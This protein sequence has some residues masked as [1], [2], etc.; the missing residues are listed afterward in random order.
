MARFLFSLRI[1]VPPLCIF[2][3]ATSHLAAALPPSSLAGRI[4]HT[5]VRTVVR[6]PTVVTARLRHP[7]PTSPPLM[8]RCPGHHARHRPPPPRRH[9]SQILPGPSVPCG[10]LVP[11]AT[12]ATGQ[13]SRAPPVPPTS[14]HGPSSQMPSGPLSHTP[15]H[16]HHPQAARR[17]PATSRL[18]VTVDRLPTAYC[19]PE[20]VRDF[21]FG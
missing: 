16:H 11:D 20:K 6:S 15:V 7:C 8:P 14:L 9:S 5:P 18:F 17:S 4:I 12:R 10:P 1:W 2:D 13:P 3:A 19:P 21:K